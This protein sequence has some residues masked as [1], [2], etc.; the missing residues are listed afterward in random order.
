M[1][2]SPTKRPPRTAKPKNTVKIL[3]GGNPQIAKGYGDE[4]VQAYLRAIPDWKRDVAVR[5]DELITRAYPKVQKA[6]KWNTPMY[7]T[8]EKTYFM[9]FH[10]ITK[11]VKVAFFQG[12]QLKPIPPDKS[13]QKHV[14]YLHIHE[15]D[16]LDEQQFI[17]WVKQAAQLPGEKM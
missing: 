11:Y 9:G 5:L 14:R 16:T 4:V 15:N 7:G 12:A 8:D 2:A 10:M 17:A 13:T 3:T 6:V 1:A